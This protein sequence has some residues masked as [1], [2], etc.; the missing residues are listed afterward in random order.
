MSIGKPCGGQERI[1]SKAE[2]KQ[3]ISLRNIFCIIAK[4]I[5]YI[6]NTIKHIPNIITLAN[7]TFGL[8]AIMLAFNDQL[9]MASYCILIGAFFDFFDGLSARILKVSSDIGK[10]LDSLADIIT[11]GVAPSF[12]VFNLLIGFEKEFNFSQYVYA[13]L[14]NE[15][16]YYLPF[17]ALLIPL[18]SA[19]RLAKFNVDKNQTDS[20]TGLPTPANALFY[21]AIP[22]AI[23]Y[24]NDNVILQFLIEKE[25]LSFSVILLCWLM[26]SKIKY[27][28]LKFKS[29]KSKDHFMQFI[30]I[31]L[32]SILLLILHFVAIPII[33]LLYTVLSLINTLR[34]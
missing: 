7:L 33:I 27:I 17:L 25:V 34:K 19:L 30:L 1:N 2:V 12:I 22:I 29:L 24:Q 13:I 3:R 18:F 15:T 26:N 21:I 8:F 14:Q 11:F 6:L 23:Q 32:S 20:F 10:Q 4:Q 31:A 9:S 5:S 16:H 28:A